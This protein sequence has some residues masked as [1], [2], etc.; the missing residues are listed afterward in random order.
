L[1]SRGVPTEVYYPLPL[2]LQ[3]AFA[4]LGYKSGQ[5]PEAEAASER[6]VALP[7][8]PE[9]KEE[10]QSAVVRLIAEFYGFGS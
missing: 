4:Y 5:F 8:Y 2:H 10:H 7:V 3:R 1:R 6:V 9:L